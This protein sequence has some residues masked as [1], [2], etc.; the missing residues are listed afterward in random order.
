MGVKHVGR[1]AVISNDKCWDFEAF[2]KLQPCLPTAKID[3]E[4]YSERS[5]RVE[6]LKPLK[7]TPQN[8]IGEKAIS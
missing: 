2:A 5:G 8:T 1:L 7:M 4:Y 6:D 3:Q